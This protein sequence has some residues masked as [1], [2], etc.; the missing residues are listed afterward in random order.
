MPQSAKD[1][2]EAKFWVTLAVDDRDCALNTKRM[3]DVVGDYAVA[4][5]H[6]RLTSWTEGQ[7]EGP[8]VAVAIRTTR[9][10]YGLEPVRCLASVSYQYAYFEKDPKG[11]QA[12][13]IY[14]EIP[15]YL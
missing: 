2:T 4:N 3:M 1:I 13:I 8:A 15:N 10:S 11:P 9:I 5:T 7:P 12:R 6:P 14:Q